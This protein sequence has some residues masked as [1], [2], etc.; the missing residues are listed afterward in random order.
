MRTQIPENLLLHLDLLAITTRL[1]LTVLFCGIIG[2]ERELN[3]KPAGFRTHLLV[4]VGS[5]LLMMVSLFVPSICPYSNIDPGRIAA[6]VVT[7]IGFLGAGTILHQRTGIVSGLTTAASL[8]V[9]A[10]LGLAVGIGF[11]DGAAM[12]WVAVMIVL[13]ILNRADEFLERNF[14]HTLIVRGRFSVHTLE[15]VK[16]TLQDLG[17]GVIKSE[18][19]PGAGLGRTLLVSVRPLRVERREELHAALKQVRGIREILFQ[20]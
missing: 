16:Q 8:W 10:A 9:T 1:G 19:E 2:L 15:E 20:S 5:C 6:Q 18:Y 17:V 14:Y 13:L 11:F 3:H 4:G 7:G 12:A